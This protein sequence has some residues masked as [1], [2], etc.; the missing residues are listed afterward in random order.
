MLPATEV[1]F[2]KFKVK[3][4]THSMNLGFD[5]NV[6]LTVTVDG[7]TVVV[8]PQRSPSIPVVKGKEYTVEVRSMDQNRQNYRVT[9]FES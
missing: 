1:D 3:A 4:A 8:S 5:G 2:L 6:A 9:V 7:Q